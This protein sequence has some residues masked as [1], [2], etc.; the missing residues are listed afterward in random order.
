VKELVGINVSGRIVTFQVLM[1]TG[2]KMRVISDIAPCGL[3][4]D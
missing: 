1:A 3:E 4:V 2:M